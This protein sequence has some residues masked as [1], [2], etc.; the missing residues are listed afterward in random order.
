MQAFKGNNHLQMSKKNSRVGRKPP[1]KQTY[2]QTIQGDFWQSPVICECICIYESGPMEYLML[3]VKVNQVKRLTWCTLYSYR[4]NTVPTI[5]TVHLVEIAMLYN[6]E[7]AS[8]Q[9]CLPLLIMFTSITPSTL[10][11]CTISNEHR[12]VIAYL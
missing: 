11:C 7:I 12:V 1:N 5:C 4:I 9:Q 8:Y 2:K 10:Q 6:T 3:S